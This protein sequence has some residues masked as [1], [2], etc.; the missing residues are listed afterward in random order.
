M[1]MNSV[2]FA[3]WFFLSIIKNWFFLPLKT[4]IC[5]SR[6]KWITHVRSVL[7]IARFFFFIVIPERKYISIKHT[8]SIFIRS[9][10]RLL[11]VIATAHTS[12]ASNQTS[13]D[14][15][16]REK[17][18]KLK[19]C[20]WNVCSFLSRR[21]KIAFVIGICESNDTYAL[22]SILTKE[23]LDQAAFFS[24]CFFFFDKQTPWSKQN[25]REWYGNCACYSRA[26]IWLTSFAFIC[27]LFEIFVL[28]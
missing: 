2:V 3:V 22:M 26:D 23:T 8:F 21:L 20:P 1:N 25:K 16:E 6:F 17:N 12:S 4:W 10:R 18:V 28:S 11:R 7:I 13:A 14:E 5:A 19:Q 24:H 15:G 9:F 27:R